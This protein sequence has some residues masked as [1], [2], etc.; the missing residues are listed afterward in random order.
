MIKQLALTFFVLLGF[1]DN[2]FAQLG[3]FSR[4]I[5]IICGPVAFQSDYGERNDLSTNAGNT[6]FGIGIIYYLNFSDKQSYH[7]SRQQT[8]FDEHFKLRS[9]L[10]YSHTKLKHFGRWVD[11]DNG[12]LG[13]QQLRAMRGSVTLINVGLQLEYFPLNIRDFNATVGS[14]APFI[15]FGGQFS[16]YNPNAYSLLGPLGTEEN[17]FPKYLTPSDGKPHGYTSDSGN[18]W[19]AIASVGTKYKLSPLTDLMVDLQLQYYFSDWVDGL[20]A[21]P[22]LYKENRANDSIIWFNVGYIYYLE[23]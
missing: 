8:Y 20:N 18:V 9:E 3:G 22:E 5:G 15:S 19:S 10:S 13:V 6:G 21:N 16:Y 12:L 1:S 17:T 4:E 11:K 2:C 23:Y 14:F 7:Y